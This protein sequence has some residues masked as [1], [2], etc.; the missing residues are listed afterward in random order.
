[1]SLELVY[2]IRHSKAEGAHPEGDRARALSPEGW[3]RI[4]RMLTE[5]LKKDFRP[6]L[7]LSSPYLRARQTRQGFAS[8]LKD[9]A[10]EDSRDLSPAADLDDAYALLAEAARRGLR[11]VAVFTHNPL[12]SNLAELL[13]Q[14]SAARDLVFHTP[15]VAA[16]ALSNGLERRGGSLLWTLNP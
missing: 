16:L 8:L 13:L 1:M 4:D 14:P 5:L 11:R 3:Q 6:E 9:A 12:V 10:Q 15:T 2:L 7:A